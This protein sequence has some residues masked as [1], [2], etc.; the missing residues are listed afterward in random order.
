MKKLMILGASILQL[1]A[2]IRAKEMGLQVIAVDMD[3]YAIGRETADVFL[4][5]STIDIPKVVE[6][7]RILKPDGVM[8]IAS[9]MPIRTVAAVA[10]ELNLVGVTE[11]TALKAT[12]KAIMR[13]AL[14]KNNVPIPK[15]SRKTG[16][17]IV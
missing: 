10:K 4:Q 15:F 11:D 6:A 16:G 5:I 8:T 1:P 14:K 2:I 17:N 13:E 3:Q 7:A 12:N 9:D